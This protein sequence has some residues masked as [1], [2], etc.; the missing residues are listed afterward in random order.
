M[1]RTAD[2]TDVWDVEEVTL[3]G[4][5]VVG[6]AV[7]AT[8]RDATTLSKDAKAPWISRRD[9]EVHLSLFSVPPPPSLSLSLV[10]PLSPVL[11]IIVID[12][13]NRNNVLP[14]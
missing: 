13:K 7:G 8:L 2:V 9:P 1:I 4:W 3:V 12:K 14:F 11:F 5:Q 10:L 6:A